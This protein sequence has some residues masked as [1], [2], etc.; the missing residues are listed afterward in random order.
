MEKKNGFLVTVNSRGRID[1]SEIF[2][3][4]KEAY[5]YAVEEWNS[6]HKY[7]KRS[8]FIE[9]TKHEI[10]LDDDGEEKEGTLIAPEENEIFKVGYDF[11]MLNGKSYHVFDLEGYKREQAFDVNLKDLN[12]D[13]DNFE[14]FENSYQD[15]IILAYKAFDKSGNQYEVAISHDIFEGVISSENDKYTSELDIIISYLN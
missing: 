6:L 14:I 11:F 7:D 15:E 5:D 12:V 10:T 1:T 9:I 2:Y 3:S 4:Y 13:W 8:H